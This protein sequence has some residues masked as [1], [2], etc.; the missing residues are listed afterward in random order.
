MIFSTQA[1][2]GQDTL[3][4]KIILV[5]HANKTFIYEENIIII[6]SINWN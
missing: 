3:S 4:L 2:N 6:R 1:G 5:L